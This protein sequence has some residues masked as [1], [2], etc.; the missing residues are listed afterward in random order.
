MVENVNLRYLTIV[1]GFALKKRTP[2][3]SCSVVL[4]HHEPCYPNR[5]LI[6][7]VVVCFFEGF[8][9]RSVLGTFYMRNILFGFGVLRPG[10]HLSGSVGQ[11]DHI[12]VL[13]EGQPH[14]RRP[15][16][17]GVDERAIGIVD[18]LLDIPHVAVVVLHLSQVQ[19][20]DLHHVPRRVAEQD[21]ALVALLLARVDVNHVPS[22]DLP[23][24]NQIFW[25]CQ[26]RKKPPIAPQSV[27]GPGQKARL[28]T[29]GRS[30][31]ESGESRY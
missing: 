17:E 11:S 12:T 25:F 6:R 26:L 22:S 23:C 19:P 13:C 9:W 27:Q 10:K 28:G 14:S 4:A 7:I 15:T 20:L 8:L 2:N 21:L 18:L 5:L 30:P 24:S 1:R 31:E 3:R 29:W 16:I